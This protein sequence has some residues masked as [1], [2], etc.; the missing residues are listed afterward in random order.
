MIS[1][2]VYTPSMSNGT[3]SHPRPGLSRSS[4]RGLSMLYGDGHGVLNEDGL[5]EFCQMRGFAKFLL[6]PQHGHLQPFIK[7]VAEMPMSA[8]LPWRL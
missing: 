2:V 5:I 7:K 4:A 1:D 8:D 3:L 6:V